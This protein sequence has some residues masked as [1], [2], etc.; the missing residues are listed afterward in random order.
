MEL[1]LARH[2]FL[3][4]APFVIAGCS[5]VQETAG[6]TYPT[7]EPIGRYASGNFHKGAAEIVAWHKASQSIYVVNASDKT[8]EALLKNEWVTM[9][10]Y[11]LHS[12]H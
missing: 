10:I 9:Y 12:P 3:L 8:I 1:K 2:A 6:I 5:T 4:A 11:P 7:M